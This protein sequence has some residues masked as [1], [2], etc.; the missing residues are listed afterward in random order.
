LREVDTEIG[1]PSTRNCKEVAFSPAASVR[2][3]LRTFSAL[4]NG[5]HFSQPL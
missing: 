5:N 2:K 4:R 3:P 1:K